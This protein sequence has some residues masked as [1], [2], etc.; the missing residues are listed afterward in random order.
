MAIHVGPKTSHRQR[1]KIA[2]AVPADSSE[3]LLLSQRNDGPEAATIARDRSPQST[4]G[5]YSWIGTSDTTKVPI[6]INQFPTEL[7]II[8]GF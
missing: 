2:S 6:R 3:N 7:T 5:K 8:N 4:K 1:Y